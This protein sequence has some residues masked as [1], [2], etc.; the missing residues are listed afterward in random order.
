MP[1][2]R[3]QKEALLAEFE[4]T[5]A[6]AR[7]VVF[8][9]YQGLKV[10]EMEALRDQSFA[11]AV[12]LRI[13]KNTILKLAA[14]RHGLALSDELLAQPLA[15]L[16]SAG[17]ELTPAKIA[18]SFAKEHEALQIAGG[19][20][21]GRLLTAAEVA[22]L[23]DLPSQD[24]LRAQLVGVIAFPLIGLVRTLQAPLAGL[25]NVLHQ[26]QQQRS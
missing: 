17:D 4:Q 15:L 20:L 16:A 10:A 25:V 11:S 19:V 24:Q 26:Y 22:A 9:N 7:G 1:K 21:E 5:L 8:V 14:R 2:T 3:R 12:S 6:A 23:A 13:T 18:K